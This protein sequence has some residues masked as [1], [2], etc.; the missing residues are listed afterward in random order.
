MDFK[1]MLQFPVLDPQS[2]IQILKEIADIERKEERPQMPQVTISTHSDSASGFF[3]N[4]DSEKHTILLC[5]MYDRKSEF[6]YIDS[7][8]I[9]SITLRNVDKYA[10]LLSD[11][12]V[13][14]TPNPDEIPTVLQL[15]KD[16]KALE[17]DLEGRLE[18]ALSIAFKYED[19]PEDI[20]KYY[21]SKVLKL[22][23]ST[24]CNIASDPLA[25]TAFTEAVSTV[26]FSLGSENKT[27]KDNKVIS[28]TVNTSKGLKSIVKD[29]QLQ[30]QIEK[31]L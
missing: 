22:L 2:I 15:K 3:V 10:Y 26:N 30:E 6:Q 14:L 11:G 9:S 24:F 18:K 23:Q 1:T 20:E 4:Y 28:I 13:P 8:S 25:K 7:R 17:E 31:F 19:T 29:K 16:I 5:D 12:K 27:V 21:A